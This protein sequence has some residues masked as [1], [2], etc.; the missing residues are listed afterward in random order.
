MDEDPTKRPPGTE[1]GDWDGDFMLDRDYRF[2]SVSKTIRPGDGVVGRVIWDAYG[3]ESVFGAAYESVF[4]TG[5]PVRF[6][7]YFDGIVIETR[8][9][10]YGRFLRVRYRVLVTV[11]LST[12]DRLLE[13]MRLATIAL[14]EP[15]GTPAPQPGLRPRKRRKGS[16]EASPLRVIPGS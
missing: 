10:M 14:E 5:E 9:E 16:A 15:F 7:A 4:V 2:V 6:R 12:L 11:D 8:A 13:T 3:G 1:G